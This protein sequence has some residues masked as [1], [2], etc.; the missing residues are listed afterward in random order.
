[1]SIHTVL[2]GLHSIGE[3]D[4]GGTPGF[5][6]YGTHSTRAGGLT[7]RGGDHIIPDGGLITPDGVPLLSIAGLSS[8]NPAQQQEEAAP[9]GS[10]Q[11]DPV[12]HQCIVRR[13]LQQDVT[14]SRET[15]VEEA[16]SSPSAEQV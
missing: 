10:L 5:T 1:M 4:S 2:T 8:T 14:P 9:T 15:A 11:A 7:D 6:P 3:S 16:R 13:L 12:G